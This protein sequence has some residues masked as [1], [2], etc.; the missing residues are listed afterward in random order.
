CL[1]RNRNRLVVENVTGAGGT[2][3]STRAM[4]ARPDGYTI[5]IETSSFR[6]I[7]DARPRRVGTRDQGRSICLSHS[8]PK[9]PLPMVRR[10]YPLSGIRLELL[11]R[12]I[13]RDQRNNETTVDPARSV[14]LHYRARRRPR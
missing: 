8:N 10:T 12:H 6:E 9:R 5:L 1:R 7:A 2:T 4:R 13:D 14:E 11:L 3:G